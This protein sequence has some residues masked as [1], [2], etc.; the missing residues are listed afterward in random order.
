MRIQIST[1]DHN[2]RICLPNG[3]FFNRLTAAIG[4]RAM[5][6]YAPE[7]L[8]DLSPKQINALFSEFRRIKKKYGSLDL[9]DVQSSDGQIVKIIL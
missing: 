4:I 7:Q 2:I 9:V 8:R 1:D 5:Q 6:K 3:L